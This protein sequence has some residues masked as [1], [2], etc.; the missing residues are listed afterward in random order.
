M[1]AIVVGEDHGLSYQEVPEPVCG[2]NEAL[3]E[4]AYTA[5]N[6]ADLA[7]R[8]GRY[9]PPEGAS[10]ILGLECAGV[11]RRLPPGYRGEWREGDAICTL[12]AGGG[13]A[14]R[15]CAPAGLLMPVPR[16]WTL[17]EAAAMPEAF[18]TAFLNLFL[19]AGLEPGERVLIHGGASGV[20]SAAIQLARE[21]GATVYATAGREE[22][23][24]LCRELGAQIAVNYR[25]ADFAEVLG[26]E[27]LGVD[28]ILD[29]VGAEYLGRNLG[30]L[31]L[32][33]RLVV[34]ATLS[35]GRAE[36]DLRA[37]MA[38]RASIKGST[39]RNRSLDEKIRI[40]E[41]FVARFWEALEAGRVKPVLERSYPIAEAEAAQERMRRNETAG[42]VVLEVGG[43]PCA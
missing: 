11:I 5:L 33:G 26:R 39:L 7:Q 4:V 15:V 12:L 27:A 38:R 2:I 42:K 37:L 24:A 22:K 6:R 17:A 25:E 14:E 16:G 41:A 32:G 10:E 30:L 21:A 9:P 29:M 35:G 8:A 36:L 43:E 13:Y 1:K 3:I 20:G 40:K 19:E 31:N 28:V 34:I 18:Y 23:V